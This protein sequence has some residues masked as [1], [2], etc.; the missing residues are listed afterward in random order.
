VNPSKPGFDKIVWNDFGQRQLAQPRA[1]QG[2]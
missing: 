2:G 1:G